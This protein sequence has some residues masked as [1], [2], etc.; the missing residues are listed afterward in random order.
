MHENS[1]PDRQLWWRMYHALGDFAAAADACGYMLEHNLDPADALGQHLMTAACINYSKP[2]MKSYG[3]VDRLTDAFVPKADRHLH[4]S[5]ILMRNKMV[6]HSDADFPLN[7]Q[8]EHEN[9]LRLRIDKHGTYL[10]RDAIRFDIDNARLSKLCRTLTKK[11]EYWVERVR[12]KYLRLLPHS[13]GEY[14]INIDPCIDAFYVKVK[15]FV[16]RE[17]TYVSRPRRKK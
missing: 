2:F 9:P 12:S 3:G 8:G 13:K 6:A 17:V 5:V 15:P 11:A 7:E 14:A 1:L 16:V 4:R 10:C